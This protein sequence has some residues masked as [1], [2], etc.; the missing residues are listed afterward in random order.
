M[1]IMNRSDCSLRL[2][3]ERHCGFLLAVFFGL[4]LLGESNCHGVKTFK[5]PA[6][7]PF[8]KEL[9]PPANRYLKMD[10]PASVKPSDG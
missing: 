5:Q 9:R 3:Y 2:V 4:L 10:S 1:N 6:G 7:S 8:G